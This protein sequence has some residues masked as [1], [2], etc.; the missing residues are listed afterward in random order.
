MS[1]VASVAILFFKRKYMEIVAF[2]TGCLTQVFKSLVLSIFKFEYFLKTK[3]KGQKCYVRTIEVFCCI[4]GHTFF[5]ME[6][7][8]SC[9][10]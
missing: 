9:S 8:E 3:D 2:E 7:Y 6:I 10:F 4:S 5:E 1:S